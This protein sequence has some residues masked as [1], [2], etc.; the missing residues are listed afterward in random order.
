MG[1]GLE[2]VRTWDG[3]GISVTRSGDGPRQII[4]VHG[5]QN[6][7]SAWAGVMD[8]LPA[9]FSALAPDLPG[10][11]ASDR[12]DSW[13]RC[14]IL[15]YAR[16]IAG[17]IDDC[18]LTR[19]VL[20]GHSLGAGIGLRI[21]LDHPDLLGSLVLVSPISTRG[22]D[23]VAE[24]QIEHL[25]H[26]TEDEVA[27][28]AR[29]AFRRP[30]PPDVLDQVLTIVRSASP[31]HIEGAVWSMQRF[32]VE[33]EL[34][35]LTCRTLLIAGDRDQHVPIRNH[36]ATAMAIPRCNLQV[37]YDVGHVPFVEVSAEFDQVLHRFLAAT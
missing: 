34:A 22:L 2:T 29:A 12:P 14:T 23:F 30:L 10:C 37:F 28:L 20:V 13:E 6:A 4:F 33:G 8:R 18:G 15:S 24:D 3:A 7:G 19:P 21:A 31:P 25:A 36:L 26:P 16:D 17:L 27:A 11:G 9:G 32:Q 35:G 1:P 5:F